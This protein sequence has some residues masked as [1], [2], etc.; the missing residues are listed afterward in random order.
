MLKMAKTR[1]LLKIT[2]KQKRGALEN[3]ISFCV[4]ALLIAIAPAFSR[5]LLLPIVVVEIAL[6]AIAFNLDLLQSAKSVELLSQI[7]FLFLMFLVGMEV[8][9]RRLLRL[10]GGYFLRSAR[11]L[12]VLYALCVLVVWYMDLGAIFIAILPVMSL[13]M[14]MALRREFTTAPRWISAALSVGILGE[15]VSIFALVLVNGFYRY[16]AGAELWGALSV[17]GAF[18]FAII[19]TFKLADTLFWWFPQ[20]KFLLVPKDSSKNEDIRFSV[21]LFL[22]MIG[23]A[24]ALGLE[25]VLGAFLAGIMLNTYFHYSIGLREKLNEFG[26]GFFIPF[27]FVVVGSTLDFKLLF[28]WEIL[29]LLAIF[30]ALMVALRVIAAFIAYRRYFDDSRTTLL[31]A[32]CHCM[33]LTFLIACAELGRQINAISL[34][35]YSALIAAAILESVLGILVIKWI[36]MKNLKL[37]SAQKL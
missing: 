12:F 37:N 29:R 36:C 25:L 14:I 10:G 33:P 34:E 17:L 16:G 11:Y 1:A 28:S 5:L 23:V 31:F 30:I 15:L 20:L 18:L 26:F 2:K 7:G 19:G 21:M 6:G 9:L 22:V 24:Y 32:L 35:E 4:I 27:F 8:D 3:I 13:G